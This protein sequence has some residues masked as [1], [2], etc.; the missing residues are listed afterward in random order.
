MPKIINLRGTS[1]SGKS[2]VAFTFLKN[3]PSEELKGADGKV[4]GYRIDASSAGV[5]DPIFLLGKYTTACGGCDQIPTQ[6]DAADRAVAA[7]QS[8]GNVLME[9]LL[10]SAAGP[11]GAVTKTIHE[12]ENAIFAILDTPLETCIER[13]K[14]RRAARGDER[15]FNPKNTNDKWTQT[16]STAKV[17]DSQGYDVRYVSHERAY[18]DVLD[19]FLGK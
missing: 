7:F 6:Q 15:P 19:M 18:E 8:G 11:G 3:F 12:T 4:K 1:G 2:T 9:G 16:H 17:L 10:A 5:K 13:V 14:A